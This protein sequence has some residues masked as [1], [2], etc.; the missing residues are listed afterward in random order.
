MV[1]AFAGP[2]AIVAA[3]C[4][5][6]IQPWMPITVF[7]PVFAGLWIYTSRRAAFAS[8]LAK[9]D[10]RL[11]CSCGYDLSGLD[12]QGSCPECGATYSV[13]CTREEWR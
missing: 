11:C 3:C 12:D 6:H 2:V 1:L 8:R 10:Y 13:P 5:T 9:A 4:R 7:L